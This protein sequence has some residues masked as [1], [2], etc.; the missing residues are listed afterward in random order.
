MVCSAYAR[1]EIEIELWG[2]STDVI[3][4]PLEL[5]EAIKQG[6]EEKLTNFDFE[7]MFIHIAKVK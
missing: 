5:S 4:A 3:G 6:I 7:E 2:N 1:Y